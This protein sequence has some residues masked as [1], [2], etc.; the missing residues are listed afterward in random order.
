M[1][2]VIGMQQNIDCERQVEAIYNTLLLNI[3]DGQGVL[4][5]AAREFFQGVLRAEIPGGA[6]L[7][8]LLGAAGWD[9]Y[10]ATQSAD[11]Q[12]DFQETEVPAPKVI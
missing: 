5:P 1:Q 10:I 4:K 3:C 7:C 11:I 12:A 9:E 8:N 2:K 6:E